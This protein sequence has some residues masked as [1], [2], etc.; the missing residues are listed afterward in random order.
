M[1]SSS[2]RGRDEVFCFRD[3]VIPLADVALLASDM[4]RNAVGGEPKVA[5]LDEEIV[6]HIGMAAE[7]AGQRPVCGNRIFDENA[8]V[9]A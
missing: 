6:G 3:G 2:S 8:Y 1:P 4:E 9:Y 7:F 5:S